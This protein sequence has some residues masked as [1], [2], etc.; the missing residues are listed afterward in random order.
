MCALMGLYNSYDLTTA[1]T[2]NSWKGTSKMK[3]CFASVKI[4]D[5]KVSDQMLYDQLRELRADRA[6]DK[7]TATMRDSVEILRHASA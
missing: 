7:I 4:G 6:Q 1:F 3:P 5:A 2:L